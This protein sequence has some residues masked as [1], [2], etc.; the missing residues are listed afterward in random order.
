M[1]II[2]QNPYRILGLIVGSSARVQDNQIKNLRQY[3]DAE[4]DPPEDFSFPSLGKFER[5]INNVNDAAQKLNLD[6]DKIH[7]GLFW[8]YN[9]NAITDEP[10]FDALKNGEIKEAVAIW[11]NLVVNKNLSAKNASAHFNWATLYLNAAFAKKDLNESHLK[12]GVEL[13]LKLLDS[14]FFD[15]FLA[16]VTDQTAVL[17]K[18][19]LQ[20]LFLNEIFHEVETSNNGSS[21]S[22]IEILRN[23]DF[24]AKADFTKSLVQKPIDLI[25]KQVADVKSH[26]ITNMANASKLGYDLFSATQVSLNLVKSL[27]GESNIKYAS[28]ADKVANGVLQCSID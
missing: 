22:F 13:K 23:L 18:N 7:A 6:H 2:Q 25:E 5:S 27:L 17:S 28:I 3:I 15:D 9:G 21:Q 26:R 1:K 20:L 19:D 11:G 8:F 16:R 14:E 10:A 12:K 4:Q 24:S